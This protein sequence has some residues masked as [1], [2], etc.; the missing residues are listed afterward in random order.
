MSR[1]LKVENL[2]KPERRPQN[3]KGIRQVL[4]KEN[5]MNIKSMLIAALAIVAVSPA[6]HAGVSVVKSMQF[7]ETGETTT[8]RLSGDKKP[9]FTVYRMKE[10]ARVVVEVSGASL[11]KSLTSKTSHQL[12][13]WAVGMVTLRN[14]PG[15]RKRVRLSAQLARTSAYRITVEGNAVVLR[16]TARAKKPMQMKIATNDKA[17]QR[18]EAELARLKRGKQESTAGQARMA[19]L[20]KRIQAMQASKLSLQQ[21]LA[22]TNAQR[23]AL[24][25]K[26][27]KLSSKYDQLSTQNSRL[28]H[29]NSDLASKNSQ[30]SVSNSNLA[31]KNSQLSM[32]NSNLANTNSRLAKE[33]ETLKNQNM[34][35]AQRNK[36]LTETLN[37]AQSEREQAKRATESATEKVNELMA[38]SEVARNSGDKVALIDLKRRL[39]NTRM[40]KAKQDQRLEL[41]NARLIQLEKEHVTLR[42]SL[43]RRSA[44]RVRDIEYRDSATTSSVI[45]ELTGPVKPRVIR[46]SAHKTVLEIP[47]SYLPEAHRRT[48]DLTKRK[49]PIRAISSYVNP[50]NN[51]QAHIVVETKDKTKGILNRVGNTYSWDFKKS[52]KVMPASLA[53][54]VSSFNRT[55]PAITQQVVN[56]Y[57]PKK[58]KVYRGKKYDLDFKDADI[59]NLLRTLA[60]V[61]GVNIVIPDNI[62]ERVTVRL[63]RVPWDQAFEV[64]LSSKS[65]WY[66]KEGPRIYRIDKRATL[67]AEAA[68]LAARKKAA[69][70]AEDPEI[71]IFTLN[72][73][74]ASDLQGQLKNLKSKNGNIEVNSRTNSLIISDVKDHRGKIIALLKQLDTPTP[75]IQ[76]EARIV[77]A[78]STFLREIGVQWGGSSVNSAATGNSTGAVFPSRFNV[79]GGAL[80]GNTPTGGI[81][82]PGSPDF[83]VNLP[84]A[85][86]LGSGGAIGFSLGSITESFGLN[87]RISALEDQ[88]SVRIIS[89]PKIK[90]VNNEEAE[91]TQGVSIPISQVA[92]TGVQTTFVEANLQLKVKPHV[93]QRDCSVAMEIEVTKNEADFANVGARGDPTI[94]QKKAKTKVLVSDGETTVLGGIYTRNSGLAYSKVPLLGDI[95]VLGWLFKK[96]REN[97][98]RTEMLIFVT[99]KITNKASLRCER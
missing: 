20:E 86:G 67:D 46:R 99:P 30:L 21:Q 35:L 27:S 43:G 31:S 42:K 62:R 78:R 29:A 41:A 68:T 3:R 64:I 8:I 94:L 28:N 96:R 52:R 10:P 32:S 76:V 13:T 51:S 33:K 91:I 90:V 54:S 36:R 40:E 38:R 88:G 71:E 73:A 23:N 19:T 22:A 7:S 87:F 17:T 84:A 70:E 81:I 15:S 56:A 55:A 98:E 1:S 49:G 92:A 79:G 74:S 48:I 6:A 75:Q 9:T 85:A 37:A 66:K 82:S 72:Y 80:D 25:A 58:R 77:E 26:N 34:T 93:S 16:V 5:A 69:V 53:T 60:A 14:V 47:A 39:Q 83:A 11:A 65:L 50:R 18:L 59:H 97:D 95:P 89:A 57:T 63:R 44:V 45:V 12:N 4:R 61:G 2:P 24:A